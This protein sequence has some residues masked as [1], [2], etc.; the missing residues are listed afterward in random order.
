M[1]SP[2]LQRTVRSLLL[3]ATTAALACG[4]FIQAQGP[5]SAPELPLPADVQKPGEPPLPAKSPAPL[6]PL[7]LPPAQPISTV[8][9][10][11]TPLPQPPA[12]K[13]TPRAIPVPVPTPPALRPS[14]EEP[15]LAPTPKPRKLTR[16]N[17]Q[18]TGARSFSEAQIRTAIA[19]QLAAIQES[20][21]SPALAD[22]TAFFL[23]VFYRRNG[24]AQ[25]EVKWTIERNQTLRLA[26]HEGPVTQLGI[27]SFEGNTQVAS[28]VLLDN[29]L[30][31]TK[32]RI[33]QKNA[34]L[35]YVESDIDSGVERIRGF[36]RSEGYLDAVVDPPKIAISRDNARANVTV[37]IH[38]G[39]Q[40]RFGKLTFEG[41]I[42]FFPQAEL[43]KELEVFTSKPY[44]PL[45]VTNLERKVAYFYRSRGY[46]TVKVRSE[47]D[48]ALAVNGLVP[49]KFIVE[50]GDIYRFDGVTQSGLR[51]LRPSF[52]PA[53]FKSLQG[54]IY[55]PAK[56]E[57][58]YRTLMGTGLFTNLKLTQIPLPN[59]EVQ[60]HF[61]VEEAKARELGFSIGY[62]SLEGIILGARYVDRNL[63][64]FGRPL[65]I[66]AEVAQQ[67]L[68][69]EFLYTD[70]WIF[71]TDYTLRLRVYALTQDLTDYTKVESGIRTEL[72]RK[73]GHLELSAFALVRAVNI[74]N[75]GIDPLELGPTSYR[76]NSVGTSITLD[77]R[78]SLLNPTRGF[79]INAT[80]DLSLN[81]LGSSLD[82][83]R[84]TFRASYYL[85]V[86][87]T[88]LA[89]GVRGGLI[90]PLNNSDII[91]IDERFFNGG[92]R[93]VRSY[94]E[95]SLGPKDSTGHSVGGETFTN[96]NIEDV[97]PLYGNLDGAVFFDAGSV[98]RHV[99]T[100]LG[101]TGYALGAGIRYKLPIGPIRL[102]YGW[103]PVRRSDQPFGALHLSFGFAF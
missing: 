82:F 37:P 57:E 92:S 30:G 98:G 61:D 72:S 7:Q 25:A 89:M 48:P 38:E 50:A 2:F 59:H 55:D 14:A 51:R 5:R 54:E 62:G 87:K 8:P 41:D 73:F 10:E 76:A 75:S 21:L 93:S 24:F 101:Q 13:P 26:I 80:T 88:L 34:P 15:V 67:L 58:R 27:I 74:N 1:R 11:P 45:A 18:I 96:A 102:D 28:N 64:G 17:L 56:V 6:V 33:P 3:L 46:F 65:A 90:F 66:S 77:Y 52:L 4:G 47:S 32:E 79:V 86:W 40:Y 91:P 100:G 71:G 78:D 60:L 99:E 16:F 49:V 81:A 94:V 36:Y 103:N 44:T 12:P 68:R 39:T 97:F 83:L 70:P 69:G 53:R 42:V 9:P 63:F 23:G 31:P 22:D 29:L 95:R 19:E 20:G 85:P 84:S 35:P 43:L